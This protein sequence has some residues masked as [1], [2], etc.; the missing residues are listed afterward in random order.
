[1]TITSSFSS[2]MSAP[3]PLMSAACIDASAPAPPGP[4]LTSSLAPYIAE[5]H[6]SH[7]MARESLVAGSDSLDAVAPGQREQRGQGRQNS[8]ARGL[9]AMLGMVPLMSA[10]CID[11]SAPAPPGPVLT[12]SLAPYIAEVHK[13]H[14]MARESLVGL[15]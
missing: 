3:L 8:A 11:A 1:M 2:T 5:V 13:S 15:V 6:K 9:L 7:Q 14:Q 10:A 12:S 4:V